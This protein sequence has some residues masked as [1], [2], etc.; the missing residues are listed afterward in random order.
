VDK[1]QERA[2][3][4]AA[5]EAGVIGLRDFALTLGSFGGGGSGAVELVPFQT[6]YFGDGDFWVLR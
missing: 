6:F 5:L 1:R 2:I 4:K 3:W